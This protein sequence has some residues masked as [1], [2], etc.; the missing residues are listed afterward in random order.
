MTWWRWER[1]IH[2]HRQGMSREEENGKDA[3][4]FPF[5]LCASL[6]WLLRVRGH[7]E[8]SGRS[9]SVEPAAW[10]Y[11]LR[12]FVVWDML[13]TFC[14]TADR[15]GRIFL[16]KGRL[17]NSNASG[18]ASG[19]SRLL[20]PLLPKR[21]RKK[22]EKKKKKKKKERKKERER[23]REEKE[24]EK[25][26]TAREGVGQVPGMR[27]CFQ[28]PSKP[29]LSMLVRADLAQVCK[30]CMPSPHLILPPWVSRPPIMPKTLRGKKGGGMR[31]RRKK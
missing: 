9:G 16:E 22:K 10:R 8:R 26:T 14:Q 19:I 31:T 11:F 30:R 21:E 12:P 7:R 28:G 25:K 20:T 2:F 6:R 13:G 29:V 4:R 23:E 3:G 1:H 17:G 18:W 27:C 15:L 24:K 5:F